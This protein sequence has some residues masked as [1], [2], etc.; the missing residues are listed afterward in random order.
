MGK[1][2]ADRATVNLKINILDSRTNNSSRLKK[3]KWQ[4][5]KKNFK[6]CD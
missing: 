1:S 4:K 6:Q 5:E 3:G 2:M